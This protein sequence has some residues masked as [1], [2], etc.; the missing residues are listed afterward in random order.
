MEE[1][2]TLFGDVGSLKTAWRVQETLMVRGVRVMEG[3]GGC[4]VMGGAG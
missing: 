3:D 1:A 2:V 4:R